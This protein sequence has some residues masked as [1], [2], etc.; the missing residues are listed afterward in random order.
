MNSSIDSPQVPKVKPITAKRAS[1]NDLDAEQLA[2]SLGGKSG[3]GAI[4]SPS[5]P[6]LGGK[7]GQSKKA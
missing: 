3:S 5:S 7:D 2:V 6:K 1:G 4:D